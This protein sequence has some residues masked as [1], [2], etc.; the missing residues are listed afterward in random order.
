MGPLLYFLLALTVKEDRAPLR[1]G[2]ASDSSV[3][4][5]LPAGA[6]LTLRYALSGE[7]VP[8][9]KVAAEANGALVD[10]YLSAGAIDGL[11]E[12]DK[13]RREAAWTDTAQLLQAVH[14]A[15]QKKPLLS[16]GGVAAISV[17]ALHADLAQ[18]AYRLIETSQPGKALAMLE[19]EMRG[20]PDPGLLAIAG[21]AA[22]LSDDTARALE[23]WKSSLDLQPNPDLDRLYQRVQRETKNDQSAEKLYGMRVILRYDRNAVPAETARQML[24]IVDETFSTVSARLG[25][26]AEEKIVT[27]VQTR[28]AYQKATDVA[29]WT[30]GLFDGRIRI[31]VSSGQEM[32][33]SMRRALAHETTHACLSMIG[34]WPAWF[35]EGMAQKLSGDTLTPAMRSTIAQM[36]RDGKLPRLSNLSQG[37]SQLDAQHAMAAYAVSLAAIEIFYENHGDDA[38]R[39]LLR[40]PEQLPP[41]TADLDKRLGL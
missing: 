28:E 22:W 26:N 32:G 37:W 13:G 14:A 34:S 11:E 2:C 19:P 3:V 21:E 9:Y 6:P 24:G 29:E 20:K 1:S 41:V 15:S 7:S 36:A 27:I 4:A 38:M 18:K 30:G 12:F 17:P 16:T 39:N 23:Y 33:P 31:P 5:T 8:C 35:Q 40:N 10:G 25:C